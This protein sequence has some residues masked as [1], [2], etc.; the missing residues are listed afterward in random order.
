MESPSFCGQTCHT[1]MRPQFTAWQ[2]TTHSKV[3]CVQCHIGEGAQ[4][5][6]RYKLAGV[7]QLVHVVTNNY[8]RPIPASVADLRPALEVC[9]HCHDPQANF[10]ERLRVS[11]EYADDETNTET[12]TVMRMQVG[13][14]GRPTDAGRAIHWHADPAVRI[15][16][17]ATEADRQTI[18]YVKVTRADGRIT[19]YTADGTTSEPAAIWC[20]SRD[21]LHRLPQRGRA[22]YRTHRTTSSRPHDSQRVDRSAA[23]VRAPRGGAPG[24]RP[25]C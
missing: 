19:E 9:G 2:H 15:E 4:A 12:R 17:V 13:G 10:G 3:D 1:P 14:P 23:A 16:Y 20:G 21:G 22:S 25:V 6:V 5:F 7:R 11:R 24:Q 8:P 18:P